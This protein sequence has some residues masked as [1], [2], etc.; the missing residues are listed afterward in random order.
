[1]QKR[2]SFFWDMPKRQRATRARLFQT[3][4]LSRSIKNQ[5]LNDPVTHPSR[6]E[7]LN[8]QTRKPKILANYA[9][10]GNDKTQEQRLKANKYRT[11]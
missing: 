10:G 9:T 1:M 2:S 3:T 8:T 5:Y 6:T 7:T 4:R 11:H